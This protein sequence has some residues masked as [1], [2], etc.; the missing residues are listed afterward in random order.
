MESYKQKNMPHLM[1]VEKLKARGRTV[2]IG[3]RIQYIITRSSDKELYKRSEDPQYAIYKNLPID[4][5]YYLRSQ[6]EKPVARLFKDIIGNG[7]EDKAATKLF[8]GL[9]SLY[10]QSKS[11][12]SN[13]F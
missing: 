11:G 2:K 10:S 7:D 5:D 9:H 3:D 4:T 1:V 6:L 12:M 13:V 8:D